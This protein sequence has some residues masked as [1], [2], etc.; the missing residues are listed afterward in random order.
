[1]D[2]N[3]KKNI[4][5]LVKHSHLKKYYFNLI[6]C[7]NLDNYN[8]LIQELS[9]LLF[10]IR[11][12]YNT[13]YINLFSDNIYSSKKLDVYN[14]LI[15]HRN[16]NSFHNYK[17]NF[18]EKDNCVP[19]YS[20]NYSGLQLNFV[21]I[22][23]TSPQNYNG[24]YFWTYGVYGFNE[25][26]LIKTT[27]TT[28]A[29]YNLYMKNS[30]ISW[31]L[32]PPKVLNTFS[33]ISSNTNFTVAF[34]GYME[35]GTSQ[36]TFS[37][38]TCLGQANGIYDLMVGDKYVSLGGGTLSWT[39]EAIEKDIVAI[40]NNEFKNYQGLCFDIEVGDSGLNFENLFQAAKD[41]GLKVL[42]TIS[43]TAPYGISDAN[44]L[45]QDFFN[46]EN[47]DYISPQM[48]TNDFGTTNEYVPNNAVS[49][50]QFITY[51]TSRKNVNLS[52]IPSIFS[53][54]VK[55]GTYD[56]YNTGGTNEGLVPVNYLD[57]KYTV[58]TGIVDFYLAYN[59]Q[60][61]GSIQWI[62]GTLTVK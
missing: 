48:Y 61:G 52:I 40:K 28:Q 47:I 42:V 33:G 39:P 29:E 49:W 6:E 25:D 7:K 56:L 34:S 27:N 53:N 54:Q 11:R 36:D 16:V 10:K 38:P 2:P 23:I 17:H 1:M 44:K 51:Y 62:N 60:T 37:D 58:D 35:P 45:M 13:H 32:D 43:H 59:I 4:K 14:D 31:N 41:V 9:K 21:I 18:I 3:M 46:S 8:K 20:L 24:F 57:P 19:S 26:L 30:D 50:A 5:L 22:F 15:T 12:L 55:N